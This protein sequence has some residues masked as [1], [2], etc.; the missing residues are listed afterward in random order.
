MGQLP[1]FEYRSRWSTLSMASLL[2]TQ[3]LQWCKHSPALVATRWRHRPAA[4]H[5]NPRLMAPRKRPAAMA[6]SMPSS[7]TSCLCCP[8]SRP[9]C[10]AGA[11]R[12]P[13]PLPRLVPRGAAI[14]RSVA[15][16]SSVPGA[17]CTPC[18]GGSPQQGQSPVL[19]RTTN[20]TCWLCSRGRRQSHWCLLRTRVCA[21]RTASTTAARCASTLTS[22]APTWRHTPRLGGPGGRRCC[23]GRE[24]R[25]CCP[26]GGCTR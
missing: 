9:A 19:T 7:S 10:P 14:R 22:S 5:L 13:W 18:A 15:R 25:W 23:C 20:T 2:V 8:S 11:N 16:V 12:W 3:K 26:R 6:S 17:A 1:K 21:T 4:A 24:M